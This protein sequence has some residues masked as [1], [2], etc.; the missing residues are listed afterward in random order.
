M[1]RG[2]IPPHGGYENLHS[3]RKSL[4]VFRATFWLVERWVRLGSRTRDQMEQSARSGKQNIVEGSLASATSKETELR[5]TNVARASL[6]ELLE[7]Y[8]DFLM[9]QGV[10][11]WDKNDPRMLTLR[12]LA[13]N[14]AD[15]E[16]YRKHI[17]SKDAEQVGN[18]MVCLCR[19]VCYLL[20][21]QIQAIE[22]EFLREGGIRERMTRA[23]LEARNDGSPEPEEAVPEC[24]V[25]GKPMRRRTARQG[26][27]A[28]Q[29][30][31][32]CTGFPDCRGTRRIREG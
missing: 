21:Q 28:G 5:L 25:C 22:E 20:D 23:R 10:P 8:R 12:A 30:F 6:G 11:E 9:L 24:P 31:W 14:E 27:H 16:T 1:S 7:D 17:E 15:Y 18:V 3:Y 29:A 26:P 4:V 13:T 19:Q 2:F 32:G